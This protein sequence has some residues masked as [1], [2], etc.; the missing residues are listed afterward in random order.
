M[1]ASKRHNSCPCQADT[2]VS[3]L[4][5][6]CCRLNSPFCTYFIYLERYLLRYIYADI[7]INI[8]IN[9]VPLSDLQYGD[10]GSLSVEAVSRGP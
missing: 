7:Y 6:H 2:E 9:Q 1:S 8:S 5:I 4:L 3:N 10:Y